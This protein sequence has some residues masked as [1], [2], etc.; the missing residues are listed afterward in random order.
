KSLQVFALFSELDRERAAERRT[1][2]FRISVK[3]FL[4][5]AGGRPVMDAGAEK[6][7]TLSFGDCFRDGVE[8]VHRV[9]GEAEGQRSRDG[10]TADRR[11]ISNQNYSSMAPPSL[12]RCWRNV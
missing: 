10:F 8:I 5:R 2:L 9:S 7:N 4:V 12:R 1:A 11:G 6:Q 3:I